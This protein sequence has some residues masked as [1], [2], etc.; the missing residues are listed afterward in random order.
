M[1]FLFAPLAGAA[2]LACAVTPHAQTTPA[3]TDAPA[4][5]VVM[6]ATTVQQIVIKGQSLQSQATPYSSTVLDS[7]QV[8]DSLITQ[9]EELL[10]L[11][12]GV[13]VRALSLGGVV[14][15]IS[16]RG[17]SSSAHGGDR[18]M[19]VDGIPL[20]EAMSHADGYS[21]LNILVPLE[22]DRF[23]HLG[24]ERAYLETSMPAEA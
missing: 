13:V 1:H 23:D 19:V 9:P 8:R 24:L 22:I 20:N 11:V 15:T 10:R 16:I 4:G 2:L 18:G 14:N 3:R 6:A 21:D 17:F 12:P 7:Q 5:P